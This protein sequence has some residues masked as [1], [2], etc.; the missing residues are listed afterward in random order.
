V[1]IKADPQQRQGIN[2]NENAAKRTHP[3]HRLVMQVKSRIF[4]A[5]RTFGRNRLPLRGWSSRSLTKNRRSY[6]K[7]SHKERL[8]PLYSLNK[9][10]F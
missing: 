3:R 5:A 9:K 4:G 6:A 1:I 7:K 2:A 8:F 10:M